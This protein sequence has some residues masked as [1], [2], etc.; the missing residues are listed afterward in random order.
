[1]ALARVV[2]PMSKRRSFDYTVG[3]DQ[4]AETGSRVVI[5]FGHATRVGIVVDHPAKSPI[6]ASKLRPIESVLDDGP[7]VD[8]ELMAALKW[9]ARYY[10]QPLAEVIWTALP[11]AVCTGRSIKPKLPLGCRLT[12]E[13]RLLSPTDFVRAKVQRKIFELLAA[14]TGP[15][16]I[17]AFEPAGASWRSALK[18][19]REKGWVA[20]EDLIEN[21]PPAAG[22][23][24]LI[25]SLTEEQRQ[26]ADEI[27]GALGGY[28]SFLLYGVTGS[29]KTEVYLHA[30]CKVIE[31][32][33]Q[34]LLL[35]PEINLTPQVLD[36]VGKALKA[37]AYAYHSGMPKTLRHRT[38]WMART[39]HAQI[40][41]GTRS[42]SLLSFKNLGLVVLD[43]EHDGSFKQQEGVR[44]HA[45]KV[46]VRRAMALRIPIVLGSATPSLEAIHAAREGRVSALELTKRATKVAMPAVRIIDLNNVQVVD[47]LS[48]P[49]IKAIERRL[50]Q[51]EQALV[52][53]NRRGFAPVVFC[54][55]CKWFATCDHCDVKLIYHHTE[56]RLRCH[57][58]GAS[59]GQIPAV[60]PSC[61][62]PSVELL[63]EGTQK[64]EGA[65]KRRFAG[66]RV[67]RIDSDSTK[68]Y[69]KIQAALDRAQR[70]E[71]DILVG[72]QMLAK[73]HN[74][75]N[76]TLVGVLNADRG[77]Y[78]IDFRAMEYL[79]QQVLQVAGRAGRIKRSGQVLIQSLYPESEVFGSVRAHDYMDFARHELVR[80]AEAQQ[81]PYLHHALFRASSKKEG[82]PTQFLVAARG[83]LLGLL[84]SG[85]FD[86]VRVLDAVPSPIGRISDRYRVQLLTVGAD[87]VTFSRFLEESV[88][89]LEAMRKKSG[90]RW[91]IDVDPTDF[92]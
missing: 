77:F 88:D 54:W 48:V 20:V 76:V 28:K 71:A 78:S 18:A 64:I 13:G 62:S 89:H 63:G 14:Q 70:G 10:H 92:L 42:A 2:L 35:V 50:E 23:A 38:W 31:R 19:M 72:T 84:D 60:C 87:A 16:P 15:V 9:V 82:D 45:R 79:V 26:A 6:Q 56:G 37:R 69:A 90:L 34:V 67:L 65:L 51:Q 12:A 74:F 58:C 3:S 1:M 36:R 47:G 21:L 46:A 83:Y 7:V 85:R 59:G 39:G 27:I 86:G 41:V 53:I 8:Q 5:P 30:A 73:G 80:R 75:P 4:A 25:E 24:G 43:E 40:V 33:A 52:F 11:D 91:S 22:A 81:P 66:A 32:G 57:Q 44:Y 29:G 61:D 49:L 17:D 55:E 68:G